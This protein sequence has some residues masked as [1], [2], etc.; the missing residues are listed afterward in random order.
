MFK[1]NRVKFR[2][3][4]ERESVNKNPLWMAASRVKGAH[5]GQRALR[6]TCEKQ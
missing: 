5:A 6:I 1:H 3:V 4:D 2:N